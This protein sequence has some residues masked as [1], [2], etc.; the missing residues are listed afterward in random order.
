MGIRR[1][2]T[3]KIGKLTTSMQQQECLAEQKNTGAD[4]K[5][6]ILSKRGAR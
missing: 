1:I 5:V 6:S 3:P 2:R 4:A